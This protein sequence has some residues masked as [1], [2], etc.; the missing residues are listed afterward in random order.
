[1]KT[2]SRSRSSEAECPYCSCEDKCGREPNLAPAPFDSH[3]L[4]SVL[5]MYSRDRTVLETDPLYVTQ[6]LV[7]FGYFEEAPTLHA[8]GHALDL[9]REAEQ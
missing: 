3:V 4:E 8:V 5:D 2:S 9:L 6:D 7:L 1:M